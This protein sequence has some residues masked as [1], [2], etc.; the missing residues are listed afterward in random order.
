MKYNIKM[1]ECYLSGCGSI[2]NIDQDEDI[3]VTTIIA[4]VPTSSYYCS[5]EHRDS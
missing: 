1:T 4:G 5:I 3:T 2:F